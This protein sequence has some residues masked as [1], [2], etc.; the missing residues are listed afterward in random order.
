[1][2][3]LFWNGGRDYTSWK[4]AKKIQTAVILNTVYAGQLSSNVDPDTR[5]LNQE[6]L[7][8]NLTTSHYKGPFHH[9]INAIVHHTIPTSDANA[10]HSVAIRES[11]CDHEI[12][13]IRSRGLRGCTKV[14]TPALPHQGWL[15]HDFSPKLQYV[16]R[17][18]AACPCCL[19][20]SRLSGC[21]DSGTRK[22]EGRKIGG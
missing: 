21:L 22:P 3:V 10:C 13:C 4:A 17:L 16:I 9:C 20:I 12:R 18:R 1:M 19:S 14:S 2:V 15:K 11:L 7:I 6:S 8:T 5:A